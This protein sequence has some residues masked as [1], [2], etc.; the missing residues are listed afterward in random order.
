MSLASWFKKVFGNS[1]AKMQTSAKQPPRDHTP[2]TQDQINDYMSRWEKERNERIKEAESKLKDWII[3]SIRD[4]GSL[5]FTWESGND[6]AFVTFKDSNE[7]EEDTF[8][9]LEEYIID[10][11]DIP[12]AGEF[13]M[14]GRGVLYLADDAVKAKYSSVMKGVVDYDEETDTE[15]YSEEVL[16]SGDKVLFG[17]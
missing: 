4:K 13:R 3:R 5:E 15:V 14:D 17:V 11:L 9:E 8:Q 1:D 10:K 7:A 16:D 6:E 2:P 12:D